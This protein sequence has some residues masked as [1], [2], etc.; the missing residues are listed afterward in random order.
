MEKLFCKVQVAITLTFFLLTLSA[1]KN[2]EML[3]IGDSL[4]A[5]NLEILIATDKP[6]YEIGEPIDFSYTLKNTSTQALLV[7]TL[8]ISLLT[9]LLTIL[10]P[11][12]QPLVSLAERKTV[13][14]LKPENVVQLAPGASYEVRVDLLKFFPEPY[15]MTNP[16]DFSVP[17]IY[18]LTA[19]YENQV[20]TLGS[21]ALW[22]GTVISKPIAVRIDPMTSEEIQGLSKKLRQGTLEEKILA[23]ESQRKV[24]VVDEEV[25]SLLSSENQRLRIEAA[26]TLYENPKEKLFDTFVKYLK[27]QDP[28]VRGY[29]ALALG[30]LQDRRAVPS[31]IEVCDPEKYPESYRAALKALGDIGDKRA[32]P[33]AE[34]L[35]NSDPSEAIRG[36]ARKISE[37]LMQ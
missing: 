23:L 24:G 17:G 14:Q 31:L 13:A 21:D 1:F 11:E 27:D 10:S 12:G 3:G 4:A 33:I 34:K 2:S 16:H 35:A 15:P 6:V 28:A 7:N 9:G 37:N 30:K 32:L 19:K 26:R 18:T 29:M 22:T 20:Q 5:D 8:P 25:A 36:L